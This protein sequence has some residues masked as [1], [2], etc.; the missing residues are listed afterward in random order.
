MQKLDLAELHQFQVARDRSIS[1]LKTW[2]INCKSKDWVKTDT[3]E[4]EAALEMKEERASWIAQQL[5][6]HE[7]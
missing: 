6:D 4:V 3:R 2:L 5:D 1:F 7:R